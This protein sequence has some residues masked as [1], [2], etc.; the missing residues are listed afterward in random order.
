MV[1][2]L[3]EAWDARIGSLPVCLYRT[4]GCN[5][6][7]FL[8]LPW[9]LTIMWPE[10]LVTLF[11]Q[12]RCLMTRFFQFPDVGEVWSLVMISSSRNVHPSSHTRVSPLSNDER[13]CMCVTCA[14]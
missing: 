5:L 8:D 13:P 9:I 10:K 6:K 1:T 7:K 12:L 11:C 4:L 3:L 2:S 14:S